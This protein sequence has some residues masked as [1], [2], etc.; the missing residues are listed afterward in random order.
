[1]SSASPEDD[2]PAWAI[3]LRRRR[4]AS[5]ATRSRAERS[6]VEV[7]ARA[8]VAAVFI[9]VTLGGFPCNSRTAAA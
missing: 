9:L 2:R 6:L 7:A 8:R 1:M 5:D 4:S 3:F